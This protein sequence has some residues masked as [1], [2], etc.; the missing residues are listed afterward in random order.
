[1]NPGES[2]SLKIHPSML[3]AWDYKRKKEN[4]PL[5]K[6][7]EVKFQFL[8]FGDGTGYVGSGATPLPRAVQEEGGSAACPPSFQID[9]F[10]WNEA[11]PGSSLSKLLAFN[12]PAA[13]SPVNFLI[14]SELETNTSSASLF[15]SCC[16]G[17]NCSMLTHSFDRTCVNCPPQN[18]VGLAICSNPDATCLEAIFGA[19]ECYMPPYDVD[20]FTCQKLDLD[21]C[22]TSPTPS[23]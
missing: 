22:G 5:P 19:F 9:A 2:V 15:D 21:S 11:P 16:P 18:R 12:L 13:V 3:N 20:P 7:L 4:R 10:G 6:R 14:A 1:I 17:V 23:P 8:S